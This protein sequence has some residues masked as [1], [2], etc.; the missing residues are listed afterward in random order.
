M[1]QIVKKNFFMKN[2]SELRNFGKFS[3]PF[4]SKRQRALAYYDSS[5]ECWKNLLSNTEKKSGWEVNRNRSYLTLKVFWN[6]LNRKTRGISWISWIIKNF[7]MNHDFMTGM[8]RWYQK[9]LQKIFYRCQIT[10]KLRKLA[11]KPYFS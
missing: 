7:F 3:N 11:Q 4:F 10:E 5:K 2:F 8:Y 1:R 9:N 6:C